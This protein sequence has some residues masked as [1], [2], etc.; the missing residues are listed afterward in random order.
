[1]KPD[2][3]IKIAIACV[4]LEIKKIAFDANMYDLYHLGTP[5]SKKC[6]EKRKEMLEVIEYLDKI[7]DV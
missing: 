3:A 4:K 2:K 6:S 5:Y 7:K 1:M